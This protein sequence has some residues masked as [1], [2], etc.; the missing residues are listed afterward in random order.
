MSDSLHPPSP[1]SIASPVRWAYAAWILAL[2]ATSSSLF[3]SEIMELRPCTLCWYQRV[4][5]F[6]LVLV[7]GAGIA[8][9]DRGLTVYSLPLVVAGLLISGYHNLLQL[10]IVP[11][12]LAP[13]V[14]GESCSQKQI[15]WFGFITIPM[16]SF[17]SFILI[18]ACL[19][20]YHR[21]RAPE[22]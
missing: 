17:L 1:D 14:E 10:G 8:R 16:M 2:F 22:K 21:V 20:Q 11:A 18:A 15:E 3:L 19:I 7:I 12:T 4:C 6:P 5:L 13:C 9:A